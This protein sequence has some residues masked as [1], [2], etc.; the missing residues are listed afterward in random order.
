MVQDVLHRTFT[1]L[2]S[3]NAQ[4]TSSLRAYLQEAVAN[5]IRD[6]LRYTTRRL[7]CILSD[8]PVRASEDAAPQYR[9]LFDDEIWSCYV[10][11]LE[12]LTDRDRRLIVGRAELGYSYRQLALAEDL[13]SAET[14]R[15]ATG[16][17]LRRLLDRM[18]REVPGAPYGPVRTDVKDT[19]RSAGVAG[20][21]PWRSGGLEA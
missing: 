21:G 12:H 1:R 7:H 15:K 9:E 20:S 13:S 11:A 16:R 3:L 6:Q 17:A 18:G 4:H 10:S 19:P 2:D 14:A 8:A 5:R